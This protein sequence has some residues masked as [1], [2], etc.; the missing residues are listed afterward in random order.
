MVQGDEGGARDA[1][2]GPDPGPPAGDPQHPVG[3]AAHLGIQQDHL[4]VLAYQLLGLADAG[5]MEVFGHQG[6]SSWLPGNQ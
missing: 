3:F 5:R 2:A 1:G 4:P 6:P